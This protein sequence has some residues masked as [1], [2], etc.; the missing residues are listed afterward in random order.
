MCLRH[1]RLQDPA[2]IDLSSDRDHMPT[3]EETPEYASPEAF[4]PVGAGHLDTPLW[5]DIPQYV[6]PDASASRNAVPVNNNNQM[7]M[8]SQHLHVHHA[9]TTDARLV[10]AVAEE[11]HRHAMDLQSEQLRMVSA[12]RDEM[13]ATGP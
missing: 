1:G 11:R 3:R 7:N 5:P 9:P 8:L 10:E 13:Q 2:I 12:Q 6:P 4:V